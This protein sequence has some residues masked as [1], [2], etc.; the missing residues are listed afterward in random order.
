MVTTSKG[1]WEG[2]SAAGGASWF[3]RPQASR[4]V[5]TRCTAFAS[6]YTH[7][8]NCLDALWSRASFAQC[9][10]MQQSTA[11]RHPVDS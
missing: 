8:D 1:V 3:M 4:N 10:N 9:I 6:P 11:A 7:S 2:C 5:H